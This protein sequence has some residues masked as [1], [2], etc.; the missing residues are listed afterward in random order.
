MVRAFLLADEGVEADGENGEQK[1]EKE[2]NIDA[3]AFDAFSEF[4]YSARD[5]VAMV[6]SHRNSP[7]IIDAAVIDTGSSVI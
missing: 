4:V 1:D 7:V 5:S 6:V 2:V 3:D